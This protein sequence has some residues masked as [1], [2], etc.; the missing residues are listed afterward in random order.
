MIS[1]KQ[2]QTYYNRLYKCLRVYIWPG[3]VVSEIADLEVACYQVFPNL[4]VV[5]HAFNKLRVSV[6]RYIKDDED[7]IQAFDDFQE[8]LDSSSEL[9]AKLNSRLKGAK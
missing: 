7:L 2:I 6:F 8:L 5:R 3:N 1:A 4:Q 9:F